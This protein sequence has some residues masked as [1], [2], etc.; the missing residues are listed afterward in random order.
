MQIK[1][2]IS[3]F[4]F[5]FLSFLSAKTYQQRIIPNAWQLIGVNGFHKNINSQFGFVGD[6][7]YATL[8]DT[9]DSDDNTTYDRTSTNTINTVA[10]PDTGDVTKSTLGIKILKNITPSL[11]EIQINFKYNVKDDAK[12]LN[13]MYLSSSMTKS[14]PNIK[15]EYQ[16]D[17]EGEEFY[18]DIADGNTYK[19]T[20]SSASTYDNPQVLLMNSTKEYTKISDIFDMNISDNDITDLDNFDVTGA[21]MSLLSAFPDANLTIFKWNS[22][23]QIWSVYRSDSSVNDFLELEA[24]QAYWVKIDSEDSIAP[25]MILG[26]G[27]ILSSATYDS[28]ADRKWNMLSF[29]DS[30]LI[31][32]S[33]AIFIDENAYNTSGLAIRRSIFINDII[34]VPTNISN[35]NIKVSAYINNYAQVLDM[36]GTSHWS[37]RAYPASYPS[38][39]I[40]LVSDENIEVNA[41]AATQNLFKSIANDD[42]TTSFYQSLT[43]MDANADYTMLTSQQ[44]DEYML[45]LKINK[46]ALLDLPNNGKRKGKLEV[47][48][49]GKSAFDIDIS[50][51]N[52]IADIALAIEIEMTNNLTIDGIAGVVAF[53]SDFDGVGDSVILSAT[54]R[55]LVKD[56]TFAKTYQFSSSGVAETAYISSGVSLVTFST[57]ANIDTTVANINA[58]EA[59]T[60]VSAYVVDKNNSLLMITSDTYRDIS[61]LEAA[62][63]SQFN[64]DFYENNNSTKGAVRD[65]FRIKDL[66]SAPIFDFSEG[67]VTN[68]TIAEASITSGA[69][70]EGVPQ[71]TLCLSEDLKYMAFQTDDYTI[72]SPAYDL[73]ELSAPSDGL[74]IESI[75][76]GVLQDNYIQWQNSDLTMDPQLYNN[77]DNFNLQKLDRTKG[78]WVYLATKTA[79]P[80]SISG[81]S[82]SGGVEQNFDNNFTY[83]KYEVG[84]VSNFFDKA[85][86]VTVN[87]LDTST[88]GNVYRAEFI[89]DGKKN[90]LNREGIS[91]VFTS[92]L[93]SFETD[94]LFVREYPSLNKAMQVRV[95]DG[96][97]NRYTY[98]ISTFN[99]IK[100]EVPT[101]GHLLHPTTNVDY[102]T[103]SVSGG[104]TIKIFDG[105]IS[106]YSAHH[107]INLI[108]SSDELSTY[109]GDYIFNPASSDE[110]M[111]ATASKPYYDFRVIVA[112]D[113]DLWSNMRRVFYAPVHKGTHILA[114]TDVVRTDYDSEPVA[115][116]TTGTS[117]YDWVDGN[118]DPIDSG[119]QLRVDDNDTTSNNTNLVMAYYPRN[120]TID[121]SVPATAYLSDD[122]ATVGQLGIITYAPDYVGD[123]FYIYHSVDE[124]LYYG[125]FPASGANDT[126]ATMYPLN[127]ID[128]E[129]SFTKP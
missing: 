12:Y 115:F 8:K 124:K 110:V 58:I 22:G 129:Q 120:V 48:Y 14:K 47:T 81:V 16:S 63:S 65:I 28:L 128:S 84:E 126:N 91:T 96:L 7:S 45:A 70:F 54:D 59:S 35:S 119:V 89:I 102:L 40:V 37:I 32:N 87:G 17:Y 118:G 52:N 86:S 61:I 99:A 19:G 92:N 67:N 68:W 43:Q 103:I 46:E 125:V 3:L 122:N 31:D 106:D 82:I 77:S 44:L 60:K 76:S 5:I 98:D 111:Y 26:E 117:H 10:T 123:V 13:T 79:N 105:N 56:A 53:D 11:S 121:S 39:G 21:Q 6:G 69:N 38:N 97:N 4:L 41:T 30:Y 74:V 1:L 25:G 88:S 127:L 57:A 71:S 90:A 29:N 113:D 55:F 49:V 23:D 95:Y 93:N 114:D 80:I 20:F 50:A 112:N 36:N 83:A 109:A 15:I 9:N 116:N 2:F 73:A 108:V 51:E 75:F 78:Y 104:S 64:I 27:K 66:A 18:I 24:G 100:P 107:N 42:L 72:D 101:V 85:L 94:G 33:S 34:K 62:N